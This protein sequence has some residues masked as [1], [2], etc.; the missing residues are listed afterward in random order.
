MKLDA[1][2]TLERI[3]DCMIKCAELA[4]QYGDE[5]LP[6]L[7]RLEAMRPDHIAKRNTLK[8]ADRIRVLLAKDSVEEP[9]H[10]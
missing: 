8:Q 1:P 9:C 3:E 5:I 7:T 4:D 2:V 6:L 10:G